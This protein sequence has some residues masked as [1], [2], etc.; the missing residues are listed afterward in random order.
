MVTC[1][2]CEKEFETAD[3]LA[4]HNQMSCKPPGETKGVKRY[5]RNKRIPFGVP[6]KRF[7]APDNPDYVYRVFNDNWRK[8]PGRI[9]RAMN[10]GYEVATSNTNESVGTNDDG[11]EIKGVLMRIPKAFYE[12]DQRKKQE[13]LDKVDEQIYQGKFTKAPGEHRYIPGGF[14]QMKHETKLTG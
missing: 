10:A 14:K 6:T 8:E 13:E 2:I 11:S 7:N 1:P 3:E 5:K 9:E 12:E 4:K